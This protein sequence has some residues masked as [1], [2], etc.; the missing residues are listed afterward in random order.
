MIT[1]KKI[2]VFVSSV[3][4]LIDFLQRISVWSWDSKKHYIVQFFTL[5]NINQIKKTFVFFICWF[6]EYVSIYVLMF[7]KWSD[8][9]VSLMFLRFLTFVECTVWDCD[10]GEG[11]RTSCRGNAA[12]PDFDIS[13]CR[14]SR[15]ARETLWSRSIGEAMVGWCT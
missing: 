5:R 10:N 9:C 6:S 1:I 7:S 12:L 11:E 15:L 14:S 2:V 8:Y 4:F 3:V 13:S